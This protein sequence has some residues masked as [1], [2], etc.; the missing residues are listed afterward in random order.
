MGIREYGAKKNKISILEAYLNYLSDCDVL[1]NF[2]KDKLE[3]ETTKTQLKTK[4]KRLK[5]KYKKNIDRE[6]FLNHRRRSY[7]NYQRKFGDHK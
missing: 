1:L 7:L 3:V 5:K 6:A 2:V 4:L